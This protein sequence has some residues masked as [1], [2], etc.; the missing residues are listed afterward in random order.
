MVSAVLDGGAQYWMAERQTTYSRAAGSRKSGTWRLARRLAYVS[1]HPDSIPGR[2]R[3]PPR[4]ILLVLLDQGAA[5]RRSGASRRRRGRCRGCRGGCGGRRPDGAGRHAGKRGHGD[6]ET[7]GART[8]ETVGIW[9]GMV[10][11]S[12]GRSGALPNRERMRAKTQSTASRR[13]TRA[14]R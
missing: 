8:V 12:G 9:S 4:S 7:V 11:L 14:C 3:A 5:G 10:M 6:R 1:H 13:S 2:H